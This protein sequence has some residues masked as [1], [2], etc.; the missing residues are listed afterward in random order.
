MSQETETDSRSLKMPQYQKYPQKMQKPSTLI[1]A[2]W[3]LHTV[4]HHQHCK[5]MNLHC[6]KTQCMWQF[7]SLSIR[8]YSEAT[9]GCL[10]VEGLGDDP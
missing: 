5:T 4:S 7:V 10:S 3:G 8:N 1:A 6:L 2:Q 9:N